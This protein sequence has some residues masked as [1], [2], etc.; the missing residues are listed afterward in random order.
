MQYGCGS[1]GWALTLWLPGNFGLFVSMFSCALSGPTPPRSTYK[2]V[3]IV[4][5]PFALFLRPKYQLF[6]IGPYLCMVVG[7]VVGIVGLAY[8]MSAWWS[9]CFIAH[10]Y[11]GDMVDHA[12]NEFILFLKC[13]NVCPCLPQDAGTLGVC[14]MQIYAG[15][16]L[17]QVPQNGNF[18][19]SATQDWSLCK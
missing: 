10:G 17:W 14:V 13:L 7:I 6:G 11:G 3:Q 16:M 18:V 5:W 9:V 12:L 8:P 4:R 2:F 19:A 1:T 15:L